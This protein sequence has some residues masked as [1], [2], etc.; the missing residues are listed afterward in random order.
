M[1]EATFVTKQYRRPLP[2]VAT[3]CYTL[4]MVIVNVLKS[5]HIEGSTMLRE[6]KSSFQ[7]DHES[8]QL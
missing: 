5:N 4:R 8:L 6:L 7:H 1:V 2:D 3:T